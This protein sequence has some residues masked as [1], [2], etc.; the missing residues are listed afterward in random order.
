MAAL[1]VKSSFPA[2]LPRLSIQK[3][4]EQGEIAI[5]HN[6]PQIL[7]IDLSQKPSNREDKAIGAGYGLVSHLKT[8]GRLIK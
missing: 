7:F 6:L 1:L 8:M 4:T 3:N 5:N 2:S